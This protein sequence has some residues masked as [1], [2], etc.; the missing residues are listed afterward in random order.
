MDLWSQPMINSLH[1]LK[2]CY[3]LNQLDIAIKRN[4][5][6]ILL[7]EDKAS[8]FFCRK[9][10]FIMENL[11]EEGYMRGCYSLAIGGESSE[12]YQCIPISRKNYL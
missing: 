11:G 5:H 3:A 7:Q 6:G 4:T 2:S 9:G 10:S 12:V 1:E 8:I